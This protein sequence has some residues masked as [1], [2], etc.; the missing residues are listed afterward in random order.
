MAEQL[1]APGAPAPAGFPH[2]GCCAY[3]AGGPV[4]VCAACARIRIS[5]TAS[6]SCAVCAQ[7]LRPAGR[8]P[9]E[10]CRSPGRRIGRIRALGYQEGALRQAINSYKY[11]G[12]HGLAI[13]LGRLFLAFLDGNVAADPP[14]LIVANPGFVGSGGQRF[15]HAE[16]VL[17]AAARVDTASRWPFDTGSPAA[18]VKMQP[19]LK[20]AESPAWSKRAAGYELRDA[21]RV[22]EPDRTRGKYVL[23]YDDICTTGTQLDAVAGCLLDEG[24]AARVEAVVLARAP[25]RG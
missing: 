5:E 2:C 7:R 6:A 1:T 18:I 21:L 19:T 3:L 8:C 13:V 10:L 16:A 25:W 12:A 15:A 9:N 17:A 23:V 14:G 22:P 24:E 11:R 4:S 20:S